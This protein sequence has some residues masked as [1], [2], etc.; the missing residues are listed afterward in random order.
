M[1]DCLQR[2]AE[3]VQ[4][5]AISLRAAPGSA[6]PSIGNAP[7]N[8][9]NGFLLRTCKGQVRTSPG[10][11]P[12]GAAT[13]P[14]LPASILFG[15][16]PGLTAIFLA[17]LLATLLATLLAALVGISVVVLALVLVGI[18]SPFLASTTSRIAAVSTAFGVSLTTAPP[19]AAHCFVRDARVSVL[20]TREIHNARG[21]I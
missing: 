1:T 18:R 16:L 11:F 5:V 4:S 21:R 15:S 13:A 9:A 6:T 14:A 3:I 20:T 10:H 7:T 19:S 2:Q 12:P 8:W 17:A